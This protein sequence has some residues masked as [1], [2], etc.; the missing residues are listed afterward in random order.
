MAAWDEKVEY[1]NPLAL[2]M[3]KDTAE[4]HCAFNRAIATLV[5][6][7]ISGIAALVV[8][9]HVRPNAGHEMVQWMRGDFDQTELWSDLVAGTA[10]S[11]YG[12]E[13]FAFGGFGFILG[14]VCLLLWLCLLCRHAVLLGLLRASGKGRAEAC[15]H[16]DEGC[17]ATA[18]GEDDP[19]DLPGYVRRFASFVW[20]SLACGVLA[21][22]ALL[23]VESEQAASTL[24][25]L[26]ATLEAALERASREAN[27][28]QT[29]AANATQAAAEALAANATLAAAG[30]ALASLG[31]LA[32]ASLQN[33]SAAAGCAACSAPGCEAGSGALGALGAASHCT[34]LLPAVA[35]A[36][37]SRAAEE[38]AAGA[39][40]AAAQ[41]AVDAAIG[42]AAGMDGA[43]AGK[44][45]LAGE[46]LH[47]LGTG[48]GLAAS[49]GWS[50]WLDFWRWLV[51]L[52]LAAVLA[53]LAVCCGAA[54]AGALGLRRCEVPAR[55]RCVSAQSRLHLSAAAATLAM[56]AAGVTMAGAVIV[57]DGCALL[58][59]AAAAALPAQRPATDRV[60]QASPAASV[61]LPSYK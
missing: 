39:A 26:A 29:A 43:V 54:S 51:L 4:R 17:C 18:I 59:L 6:V 9:F 58:H 60:A 20:L 47:Q 16:R 23:A 52:A 14:A 21:A 33:V 28:T 46:T 53:P 13:V 22:A 27:A 15:C 50:G 57:S 35:A 7:L 38:A 55:A 42:A 19:D 48:G 37:L 36:E 40:A 56:G 2:C 1:V 10:S 34:E 12:R 25:G 11:S 32:A 5:C 24:S 3:C 31:A 61:V 8:C 49:L 41:A 44:V 45:R 30:P